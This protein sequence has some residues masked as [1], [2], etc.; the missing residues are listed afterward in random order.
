M[1]VLNC[2]KHTYIPDSM[3]FI[4]YMDRNEFADEKL[5]TFRR[6]KEMTQIRNTKAETLGRKKG[7]HFEERSIINRLSNIRMALEEVNHSFIGK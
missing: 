7:T 3:L 2:G 1:L 4:N 5:Y 6:S